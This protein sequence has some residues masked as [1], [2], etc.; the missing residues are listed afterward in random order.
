MK[1][2]VGLNHANW[3]PEFVALSN[4]NENDRIQDRKFNF[5]KGS[6]VAF[7]KGYNDYGWFKDFTYQKVSFD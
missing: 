4:G 5:S 1:L 2:S 7:D 3:L 6:I